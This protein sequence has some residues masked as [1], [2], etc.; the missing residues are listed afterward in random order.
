MIAYASSAILFAVVA[1]PHLRAS[2]EDAQG[3]A[4]QNRPEPKAAEVGQV[5]IG[6]PFEAC[7][8]GPGG[9]PIPDALVELRTSPAPAADQIRQGKFV[10]K[11]S[12]G[13]FVTADAEGR[14]LV[15]FPQKPTRFDV[16]ITTSGYGPYWAGWSSEDHEQPI[17]L[18]FTAELEA[19]W[20]VGGIVVDAEGKPIEGAKVH[21]SIEFK[22]RPGDLQQ[23]GVGTQIKTG[24]QGR[25]RFD[26]VPESMAEVYV[27]IDHPG[28]KPISRSLT[29]GEFRIDR[30]REPSGKIVLDRGLTVTGRVT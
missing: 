13:S 6:D 4:P 19:G 2:G 11:A 24:A 30:G 20:S 5:P 18:R 16:N 15:T 9:K 10:R 22:K 29:R 25:W 12:Y 26:S 14:V 23:L 17:P 27:E 28:F 1:L 8:V 21:P 7:V 3:S